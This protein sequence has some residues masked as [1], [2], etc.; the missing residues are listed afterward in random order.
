MTTDFRTHTAAAEIQHA[1]GNITITAEVTNTGKV[2]GDEV[3][4]LYIKDKLSSVTVY[5]MQLRG[6]ERI[7]LA[8]GEKRKIMFELHPPDLAL[9][10]KNMKWVVEPGEF[11]VLIGSSSTDIPLK[12]SFT[13]R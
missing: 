12:K 13:I 7:P 11:E 1:K 6:L 5:E 4:Q 3:V 2:K 10:D 9:L 8:P